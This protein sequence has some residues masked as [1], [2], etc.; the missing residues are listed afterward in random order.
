M[1]KWAVALATENIKTYDNIISWWQKSE[2]ASLPLLW[3]RNKSNLADGGT[4]I[5]C[6]LIVKPQHF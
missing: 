4:Y 1:V 2:V 3:D 5:L 6:P